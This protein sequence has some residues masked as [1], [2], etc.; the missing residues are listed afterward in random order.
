MRP[1]S[2]FLTCVVSF[3][4]ATTYQTNYLDNDTLAA[5]TAALKKFKGAV[6]TISHHED[7]VRILTKGPY[8]SQWML[9]GGIVTNMSGGKKKKSLLEKRTERALRKRQQNR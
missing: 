9:E 7:F 3:R 2:K 1:S 6:L 8:G 5:L 4:L